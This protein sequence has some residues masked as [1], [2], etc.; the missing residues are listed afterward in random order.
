[1]LGRH[2]YLHNS[3][4]HNDYNNVIQFQIQFIFIHDAVLEVL[5]CGNTEITSNTFISEVKELKQSVET[6][7]TG[8]QT[9][10]RILS[11]VTPGPDDVIKETA[12]S[13]PD[14]N[15]SDKYLPGNLKFTCAIKFTQ[16]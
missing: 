10:F 12:E 5:T 4:T 9:Q 3:D 2:E 14:K 11:Q 6:S 15:R 8:L 16:S 1:M 7:E 13:H